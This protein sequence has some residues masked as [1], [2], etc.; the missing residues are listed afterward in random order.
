MILMKKKIIFILLFSCSNKLKFKFLSKL[1]WSFSFMRILA[2]SLTENWWVNI[3]LNL[4]FLKINW[5]FYLTPDWVISSRCS[6]NSSFPKLHQLI[7]ES[8]A[9]M[10]TISNSPS[11]ASPHI[12]KLVCNENNATVVCYNNKNPRVEN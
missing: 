6:I 4:K 2:H 5:I 10:P 12:L 9:Y 11:S 1:N 7:K 8:P 3:V